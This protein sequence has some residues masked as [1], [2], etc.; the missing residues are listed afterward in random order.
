MTRAEL[1][2]E[3]YLLLGITDEDVTFLGKL[4]PKLVPDDVWDV[5][6][7]SRDPGARDLLE[8]RNKLSAKQAAAIPFEAFIAA[9]N[10]TSKEALE[11]IG[12]ATR[13]ALAP[14]AVVPSSLLP[15]IEEDVRL[16]SDAFNEREIPLRDNELMPGWTYEDEDA[17]ADRDNP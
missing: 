15:P 3:A 5:L 13:E 9:S 8:Q 11:I 4:P 14:V 12:A 16:I 2:D 10:L 7:E 17:E 6:A 1:K